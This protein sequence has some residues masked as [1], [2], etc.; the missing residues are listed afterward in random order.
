MQTWAWRGVWATGVMV[1]LANCTGGLLGVDVCNKLCDTA[2]DCGDGFECISGQCSA[3]QCDP[4]PGAA[5]GGASSGNVGLSSSSAA[6]SSNGGG[7]SGVSNPASSAGASSSGVVA[8]SSRVGSGGSSSS[9]VVSSSGPLVSSSSTVPS[10][11]S[12]AAS[13]SSGVVNSS[14]ALVSSSSLAQ[15]SSQPPPC[16]GRS[17]GDSCGAGL[18]CETAGGACISACFIGGAI[19]QPDT[20]EPGNGCRACR[21]LV[22]TNGYRDLT[23][24]SACTDN[25]VCTTESC[26]SGTC[27]ADPVCT[28]STPACTA[29]VC[30]CSTNPV[31]SCLFQNSNKAC[32]G[33]GQCGCNDDN[34]CAALGEVCGPANTCIRCNTADACGIECSSCRDAVGMSLS[35]G[36]YYTCGNATQPA[37]FACDIAACPTARGNCDDNDLNQCEVDLAEDANNCGVCGI[38]CA[39]GNC[40]S[41]QCTCPSGGAQCPSFADTQGCTS[42][43]CRCQNNDECPNGSTCN[44]AGKYCRY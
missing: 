5:D 18:V 24:G 29:G 11:T 20:A 32:L 13:S 10:S 6:S 2:Q 16:Q 27:E 23:D 12:V 30:S 17:L 25:D 33:T 38:T 44:V 19:I 15:S 14:S 35:R 37:N 4:V 31:D 42:G 9:V 40:N 1:A 8:S 43:E 41:R 7:S 39:S 21:P 22:S 36:S 26:Q 34:D 3:S 28:G